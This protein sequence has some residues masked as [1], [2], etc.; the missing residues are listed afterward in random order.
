MLIQMRKA[1]SGSCKRRGRGLEW[2]GALHQDRRRRCHAGRQQC[3]PQMSPII[4]HHIQAYDCFIIGGNLKS[5][6]FQYSY[7]RNPI[8]IDCLLKYQFNLLAGESSTG[9]GDWDDHGH[10]QQILRSG[11]QR[12]WVKTL[13]STNLTI[14]FSLHHDGGGSGQ[15]R[16]SS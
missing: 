8:S 1:I 13:V 6:F 16:R 9:P 5:Y 7:D 10:W 3:Y 15:W 12:K 2:V 4:I 14:T 11:D